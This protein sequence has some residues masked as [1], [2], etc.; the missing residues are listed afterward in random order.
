MPS[1]LPGESLHGFPQ[2]G[3]ELVFSPDTIEHGGL[4][5]RGL[6]YDKAV[7]VSDSSG[8]G[9]QGCATTV[10]WMEGISGSLLGPGAPSMETL[11]GKLASLLGTPKM[12]D[13]S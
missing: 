10:L 1:H 11:M 7:P 13:R 8:Q 2:S 5:G 6:A 3:S 4:T 12:L 9:A